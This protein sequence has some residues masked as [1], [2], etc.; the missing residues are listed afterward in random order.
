[1][2]EGTFV[3]DTGMSGMKTGLIRKL[4]ILGSLLAGGFVDMGCEQPFNV[5]EQYGQELKEAGGGVLN[6]H[7]QR[8]LIP[9]GGAAPEFALR[10]FPY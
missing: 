4:M 9:P 3:G 8:E 7:D 6:A 2:V 1:M 5:Y 10:P